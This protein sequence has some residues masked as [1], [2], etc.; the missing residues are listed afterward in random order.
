[1]PLVRANGRVRVQNLKDF[2]QTKPD[3]EINAPFLLNKL[4][5][6]DFLLVFANNS[7]IKN[8][9]EERLAHAIACHMRIA[10]IVTFLH[11]DRNFLT[12]L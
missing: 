2:P 10:K 11:F 6:P 1:M 3:S 12:T 4:G 8:I 7:L 5:D 9:F